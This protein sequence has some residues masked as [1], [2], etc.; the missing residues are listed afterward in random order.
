MS[1]AVGESWSGTR[2]NDGGGRF[3]PT[4]PSTGGQRHMAP[5]V[6]R[7]PAPPVDRRVRPVQVIRSPECVRRDFG[8]GVGVLERLPKMLIISLRMG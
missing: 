6:Y 3:S 5:Q 4:A 7:T 1:L 8:L 2:T